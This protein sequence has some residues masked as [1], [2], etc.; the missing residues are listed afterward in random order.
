MFSFLTA[1][2]KPKHGLCSTT[3][4]EFPESFVLL[5]KDFLFVMFP[6]LLHSHRIDCT[7][8]YLTL[9]NPFQIE[10][11][12]MMISLHGS[13]PHRENLP[14]GFHASLHTCD[15]IC[16]YVCTHS[17]FDLSIV[18]KQIVSSCRFNPFACTHLNF[19]TS[20]SL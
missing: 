6:Y 3:G 11:E 9:I 12:L 13:N 20:L 1:W 19:P 5:E 14:T 10:S 4:E 18:G 16:V 8:S 2:W 17:S 7:G 15:Y